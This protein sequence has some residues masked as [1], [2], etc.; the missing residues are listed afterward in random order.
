M[1][2]PKEKQG[3]FKKSPLEDN[4]DF[5]SILEANMPPFCLQNPKK[6]FKNPILRGIKILIVFCFDFQSILAPFWEPSWNHVA[7]QDDPKRHQ[8]NDRFLHRIFLDFGSILGAKLEPCC[9]PRRPQDAP[10]RRRDALKPPQ[11]APRRRQDTPRGPKR[12]QDASKIDF[13]SIF[14]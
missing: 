11:D 5:C 13:W 10:G 1:V 4:I 7:H 9:P 14:D 2:F 12:P 3:F 6:S 8:K